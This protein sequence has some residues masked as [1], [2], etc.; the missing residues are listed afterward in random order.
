MQALVLPGTSG[1][2][3]QMDCDTMKQQPPRIACLLFCVF[4]LMRLLVPTC[5]AA[6]GE[7]RR[8]LW[9]GSMYSS[10]YRAGICITSS[11][12]VYGALYLR[13]AG[14][15]V[16]RYT[17][18]GKVDGERITVRHNS[19][20]EFRG[21]FISED[22]VQGELTLKNGHKMNVRAMRGPE[23]EVDEFCRLVRQQ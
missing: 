20:H 18:S 19:G 6:P 11:G 8:E 10:T 12:D 2:Y 1:V 9:T 15:A 14:G 23:P 16:D 4:L 13:Q 7:G 17:L 22:T 5:S 3:A 21:R